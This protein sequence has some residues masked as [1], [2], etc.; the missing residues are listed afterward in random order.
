MLSVNYGNFLR[1]SESEKARYE[2]NRPVLSFGVTCVTLFCVGIAASSASLYAF[3]LFSSPVPSFSQDTFQSAQ[4][5]N[6][7]LSKSIAA[8]K[9]A[10]PDGIQTVDVISKII[11][12]KPSDVMID[13]M[14][15]A[16]G[17]YT[18]KGF[19]SA[20]ESAN[21][22]ASALDFG[23]EFQS[24]VT[25]MTQEKG[26]NVFTIDVTMKTKPQAKAPAK[27]KGGK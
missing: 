16:P 8:M 20:Q 6:T 25:S 18:I 10:R 26:T 27:P 23:K 17:H 14:K 11:E 2:F 4:A 19:T 15:I 9:N 13:S 24:A 1:K 21:V 7:N 22:F 5:L 12:M 3:S